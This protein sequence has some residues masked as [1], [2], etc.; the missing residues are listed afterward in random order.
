ME[1]N[2]ETQ[3]VGYATEKM[4]PKRD[5]G[6]GEDVFE[7]HIEMSYE[8]VVTPPGKTALSEVY[9]EEK[10]QRDKTS[11]LKGKISV[12]DAAK[13]EAKPFK[14]NLVLKT[15]EASVGEDNIR[16]EPKLPD[17]PLVIPERKKDLLHK[18]IILIE[19]QR[20]M[21]PEKKR[22]REQYT[23]KTEDKDSGSIEVKISTDEPIPPMIINTNAGSDEGRVL[24]EKSV[25]HDDLITSTTPKEKDRRR[26]Q[27]TEMIKEAEKVP[28][29]CRPVQAAP[30]QMKKVTEDVSRVVETQIQQTAITDSSR[31]TILDLS[32]IKPEAAPELKSDVTF[33]KKGVSRL[34][35]SLEEK[36]IQE[37]PDIE[38]KKSKVTQQ[39]LAEFSTKAE[40]KE[41][42]GEKSR[43]RLLKKEESVMEKVAETKPLVPSKSAEKK[44]PST[45]T[46]ARG[47]KSLVES[48]LFVVE[49]FH[50]L[51]F[52]PSPNH[53]HKLKTFFSK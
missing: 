20:Q 17:K 8:E 15:Q 50:I 19:K 28:A 43:Y 37:E 47:I 10:S 53:L 7:Q 2:Q 45:Q 11:E 52:N 25:K 21:A 23:V 42:K 35:G 4:F 39:D 27:V 34:G 38:L 6:S 41:R 29:K 40:E 44:R 1:E 31:G 9:D 46:A 51:F 32:L 18:D 24:T 22:I 3:E 33:K 16:K 49:P 36:L 13:K 26:E 48:L 12:P 14:H 30:S 5:V